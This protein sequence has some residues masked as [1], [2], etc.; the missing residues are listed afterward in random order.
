MRTR[1]KVLLGAAGGLV[2]LEIGVAAGITVQHT[3]SRT[4][5]GPIPAVLEPYY[6]SIKPVMPPYLVP[7]KTGHKVKASASQG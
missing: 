7:N 3:A 4:V 2:L 1:N 5:S 6:R